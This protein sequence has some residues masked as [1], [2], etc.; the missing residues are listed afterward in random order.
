M[1]KINGSDRGKN[2]EVLR[3]GKKQKKSI[4]NKKKRSLA[5]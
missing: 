4:D 5:S 3:T 1:E 2:E